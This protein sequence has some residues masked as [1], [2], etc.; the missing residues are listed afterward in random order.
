MSLNQNIVG[1]GFVTITDLSD[2]IISSTQPPEPIEDML[3]MDISSTPPVLKIYKSGSWIPVSDTGDSIPD[4]ITAG[5]YFKGDLI[6]NTGATGLSS[7]GNVQV[8]GGSFVHP[9]G[10]T[11]TIPDNKYIAANLNKGEGR[12]R[13]II[14]IGHDSSRFSFLY[15]NESRHFITATYKDKNWYYYINGVETQ[16][17]PIENDCIVAKL[18]ENKNI[19]SIKRIIRYYENQDSVFEA[20]TEGGAI[21]GIYKK[22][23]MLFVNA[24]VVATGKLKSVNG[25]S[26]F[27]LDK[28]TFRLGGTSDTDYSM[29][30]DGKDLYFAN[31]AIKWENLDTNVQENLRNVSVSII[32]GIRSVT[33]SAYN[34]IQTSPTAY[35]AKVMLGTEDITKSC[36]LISWVASGIYI[37][38]ASGSTFTPFKGIYTDSESYI[39][40]TV[41]YKEKQFKERVGISVSKQ[42]ADGMPG[43]PGVQ[44]VPGT[45]V[46][47]I[48]QLYKV[49]N[50][51]DQQPTPI[52]DDGWSKIPPTWTPGMYLHTCSKIVYAN[53]TS[54]SYTVPVCDTAW[55]AVNEVGVSERNLAKNTGTTLELYPRGGENENTSNALYSNFK[56]DPYPLIA[57]SLSALK[58]WKAGDTMTLSYDWEAIG[59]NIS[60]TLKAGFNAA[61]W[62]YTVLSLSNSNKKGRFTHTRTLTSS[63]AVI[64]S[65]ATAIRFRM[66]NIPSGT[67]IKVT[68]TKL[69]FGGKDS[70]WSPALEDTVMS[71]VTQYYLSTSSTSQIGG[72][73]TTTLP[74]ITANKFIWMKIVTTYVT[75]D[76][77]ET[78]PTLYQPEWIQ[79]WGG[80]QTS[81]GSTSVLSP[82]IFAGTKDSNGYAT[83]VA[84]GVNIFGS[85][86]NFSGLVGY[87]NG[88]KSYHF[89]TDGTFLIGQNTTGNHISW[90]GDILEIKGDIKGSKIEGSTLISAKILENGDD[91]VIPGQIED[92]IYQAGYGEK[93][94]R[95]VSI[96]GAQ[97]Y[98]AT[99]ID[100]FLR[101]SELNGSSINLRSKLVTSMRTSSSTLITDTHFS[102][103]DMEN[104]AITV[105]LNPGAY[106][107]YTA[108]F[109]GNVKVNG[110]LTVNDIA[111]SNVAGGQ[112][113]TATTRVTNLNSIWKSGFY[114]IDGGANIPFSGWHWVMHA[115]HANNSPGYR[116]GM[117]IAGQ[118]VSNNFAMRNVD[119]NGY[120]KWCTLYH[121]G[122]PIDLPNNGAS[123]IDGSYYGN[124]RGSKQSTAAFHPIITQ[125]TS[126]NHRIAL[127]GIGNAFGFYLYDASRT[128]NGFDKE[129]TFQLDSKNI[130][131]SC[132]VIFNEWIHAQGG[133]G[134]YFSSYGGGLYMLDS[135]W[136]RTYGGKSIYSGGGEIRTEGDMR[137]RYLNSPSGQN[138]DLQF[139]SGT[140]Y[141]NNYTGSGAGIVIGRPWSGSAGTEP[142]LYNNKGNGWGY[143]GNSGYTFYRVYGAGGSVSQRE[144][145]YEIT[146]ADTETQYEN[147]KSINIY[148]YRTISTTDDGATVEELA[149]NHLTHVAFKNEDGTLTTNT[150]ELDG[151][152]YDELDDTL[153]QDEIRELRIKEIIEKNPNFGSVDRE[154]LMLGTMVDELPLETT[155]YDN[156]GG[157]GKA[158]DMYSYTTMIAGATKHLIEK[159]ETLEK[160]NEELKNKLDKMEEILNGII[161][162]G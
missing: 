35:T 50:T 15:S 146:K 38:N 29:K 162:G 103:S 140:G 110:Y 91:G 12:N 115:G 68:N 149:K 95:L 150:I 130:Y 108:S 60:G 98:S 117:Q 119:A 152:T 80:T 81:I 20:L 52:N 141:L 44:G 120:G 138:L 112:N 134:L 30:F 113:Y 11:F 26:E 145:K 106:E 160:E 114:D 142:C 59:D 151:I 31:G 83:G 28:G 41:T 55:E 65:T 155:F 139:H 62:E 27:D 14:F 76:T 7:N 48:T 25:V 16:F 36:S 34:E 18:E 158:V 128:A 53:P 2:P 109:G 5:G 72:Q 87:Q 42:G 56:K 66:D 45:S 46:E 86:S 88:V 57:T 43:I 100:N 121:S 104:T 132:R 153:D 74:S 144:R 24:E 137:C 4:T 125:T 161:N 116:Y 70:G 79:E 61:P 126:S 51:K 78:T 101:S 133:Y 21:Q 122:S 32:G 6:I 67:I 8:K 124:I 23:G 136:I 118:N 147:L 94:V 3:W 92:D 143:L 102:M 123:W 156:E 73:W 13:Y 77:S 93:D 47:S 9:N 148:N 63:D 85:G 157:D 1:T 49:L 105:T 107:G 22:D 96:K 64:T 40:V 89:K 154:D 97:L 84:M 129:F 159:V 33:V 17:N 127:G 90:N 75:G 37:G 82:K 54:T 135:T 58:E 111:N 10:G 19:N 69:E 71:V 39:E 131:T 99:K